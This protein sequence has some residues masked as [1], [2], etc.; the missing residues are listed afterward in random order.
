M[1]QINRSQFEEV[2]KKEGALLVDFSATWCQPCKM[3]GSLLESIQ[4]DY[5]SVTFVKVDIDQE[6]DLAKE[7]EVASVPTV[8]LYKDGELKDKMVGFKTKTFVTGKLDEL[9]G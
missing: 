4:D 1:E 3:L 5:Q 7:H 6:P 2:I 8:L 9:V